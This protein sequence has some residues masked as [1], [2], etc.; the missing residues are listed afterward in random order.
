MAVTYKELIPG[1]YVDNVDT[2]QYT[3]TNCRT[4]I[5]KF[6]GTNVSGANATITVHLVASGGSAQNANKVVSAR[7]IAPGETYTFPE[8]VG[9]ELDPGSFI[10]TIAGTDDVITIRASGHEITSN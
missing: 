5:D 2:V 4:V 10:S 9:H 1:K 6:T 8:L 7:Q 3:A